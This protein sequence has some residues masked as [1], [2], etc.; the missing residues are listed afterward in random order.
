[1]TAFSLLALD[2]ATRV[3]ERPSA[4]WA[5]AAGGFLGLGVLVKGPHALL[6]PVAAIVGGCLASGRRRRLLDPRWIL[7]LL[8]GAAVVSAWLVPAWLR[9][10]DAIG[11]LVGQLGSRVAG[12]DE[13]HQNPFWMLPVLLLVVGLPWTP[14]WILGIRSAARTHRVAPTDRFGAGSALWGAMGPL[15]VL[16]VPATKRDVYLVSLLPCLAILGAWVLH[17]LAEPLARIS[18]RSATACLAL[19]ALAALAAPFAAPLVWPGEA[20]DVIAGR[21]L[22]E[23]ISALA[24]AAAGVAAAAG[25]VVAWRRRADPVA[26]AR[27]TAIGLGGAWLV[28]ALAVLLRLD[29][30]KTW[31]DAL[32]TARA[33]APGAPLVT[34]GFSDPALVW[35]ARPE[36]VLRAYDLKESLDPERPVLLVLKES[37]W[38]DTI[39]RLPDLE[40]RARTLVRRKVG[41]EHFRV[42]VEAPP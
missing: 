12:A 32:A 5:A 34:A 38:R 21:S 31:D 29:A 3:V 28:V 26:C 30:A 40:T 2:A 39:R 25:A 22:G 10:P 42:L 8:C 36:R 4:G 35:A 9:D 37:T 33:A 41:G 7:A 23:G 27:S 1:M 18:A 19:V 24:L 16:S 14:A 11:R 13:P 20:G 6:V 15:L 17:R